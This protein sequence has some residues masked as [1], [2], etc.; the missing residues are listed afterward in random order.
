MLICRMV[1]IRKF[2]FNEFLI[3]CSND[4]IG[5]DFLGIIIVDDLKFW[6]EYKDEY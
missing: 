2:C 4:R 5:M 3:G 6:F 1:I